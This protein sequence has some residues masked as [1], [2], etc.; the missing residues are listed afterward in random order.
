MV[1]RADLVASRSERAAAVGTFGGTTLTWNPGW[2]SEQTYT[3]GTNAL[4]RAY[5]IPSATGAFTGS[6]TA[7]GS[8]LAEIVTFK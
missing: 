1:A 4:G 3:V 2:T 6:G 5:Q 7:S 8:W